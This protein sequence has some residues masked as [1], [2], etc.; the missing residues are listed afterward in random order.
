M[1]QL[2][3]NDHE[4]HS[5]ARMRQYFVFFV[6]SGFCSL[7]YEI[8]WLR[9]AMANFG[10]TAGLVSIVLST[11]MGGLGIGSWV[12]GIAMRKKG[13][14]RIAL[15][16]YS[17]AELLVG[18]SSV[19][20]PYQLKLGRLLLQ[21]L[22][23]L[24]Q[25]QSLTYYI[26]SGIWL[27]ITLI[28]WCACMGSTFP[29]LMSVIRETSQAESEHAFSYLYVANVLGA[30]I[31]TLCS[32]FALI[33]LLGFKGTLYFAGALNVLLAVS[34]FTL[35][36]RILSPPGPPKA[37]A[38]M[39]SQRLRRTFGNRVVLLMLFT[40]GFTSMGMEVVWVRQFTPYLG[41]VVY[42]FA[43]ILAAYLLATFVG[44]HDYRSW[45]C[46]HQ[47]EESASTWSLLALFSLIPLVSADPQ[48]P[49]R[50][51]NIDLGGLRLGGI[52]PF[53]G[54]AG[55]LTPLL[56]DGWSA[57]DPDRGGTAYAVNLV[58]S[59][60]GPLVAGFW[61]LP[62]FGERG[63]TIALA[64]PLFAIAGFSAFQ[65]I[66]ARDFEVGSALKPKLKFVL[67]V[68][69]AVLLFS[70]SHDYEQRYPVREVR[71]DYAATV[72]ATGAGF[73]RKLL[74]NGTGMTELSP[75]T[76]Y[77]AHL[78][79]AFM[80]QPAHKGLVICFGM[81]TTFRSML[82]WGISTTAV[83]VVPSVPEMFDYFHSDAR[84]LVRSP[85]ARIVV[86]D[87]RRFLDGS[88]ES[89]DVVVIDPPP[90]PA[91]LGSSLLYSPEFY[92]VV[93]K[94]LRKNG[95]VQM[96]YPASAADD[97]TSASVAR[98]LTES[99]PYV[100][101]FSSFNDYGFHFL[102]SMEPFPSNIASSTLASRM[103]P[104]AAAD[105]VEWGPESNVREQF[106]KVLSREL[107]IEKL[108][109]PAPRVPTLHDDQ[110]INEYYL[111]RQLLHSYR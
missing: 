70:M 72:I 63:S 43:G 109:Q 24:G 9:L 108:L 77:M 94:H 2:D 52:V 47:I 106:D 27:G 105:F 96:W 37:I 53:C 71:R 29:L 111:L 59:I 11:F 35:S 79:L 5:R 104:S 42:A 107:P 4:R 58:G 110:P 88:Q 10:V 31:G 101:A 91:A 21:H 28:P 3:L 60:L 49:V 66:S 90:P 50:V 87:G 78:P 40:T 36:L 12:A 103:P 65:R 93:K 74:V 95:I 18:C 15:R 86:D 33:E 44:S 68:L 6:I 8:V 67:A 82:S 99:F 41:N 61:L 22:G 26:L 19:V 62:W 64:A 55:F 16:V 73:D 39:S 20:V 1:N 7:V 17:A 14:G 100:R 38:A 76:K 97:A 32:A 51:G 56:T 30:L 89:Y 92:D 98:A 80:S 85:L 13:R 75:I 45:I 25:W 34:A 83:D 69:G 23:S 54:I 81:G 84:M 102:A 46:S 48:L 57:G